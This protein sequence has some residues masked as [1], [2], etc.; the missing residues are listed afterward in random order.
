MV[1]AQTP[2]NSRPAE[3]L[4]VIDTRLGQVGQRI[5]RISE[6]VDGL[7]LKLEAI[8][9]N[10]RVVDAKLSV[11]EWF[12]AALF[13]LCLATFWKLMTTRSA[14]LVGLDTIT[15]QLSLEWTAGAKQPAQPRETPRV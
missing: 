8:H 6:K 15:R 4:A 5:E 14:V 2:T 9:R 13:A 12:G 10:L 3:G 11:M 1:A 7:Q